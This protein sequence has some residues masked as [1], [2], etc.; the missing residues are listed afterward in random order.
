[1]TQHYCKNDLEVWPFEK[2]WFFES[3]RKIELDQKF[4]QKYHN[5]S[6]CEEDQDTKPR[7]RLIFGRVTRF[8]RVI[9]VFN[10]RGVFA[11]NK[12]ATS[13]KHLLLS[14]ERKGTSSGS[15]LLRTILGIPLSS[16]VLWKS[17]L[18]WS[19]KLWTKYYTAEIQF[20][21]EC[22]RYPWWV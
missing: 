6:V 20:R 2:L 18:H 1:M 7:Q 19:Q 15:P 5:L 4:A 22:Q 3:I 9:K 12:K 10:G 14:L 21:L 8:N 11:T 13:R 16:R 17:S